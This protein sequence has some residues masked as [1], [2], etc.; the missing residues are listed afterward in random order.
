[1]RHSRFKNSTVRLIFL[2]LPDV[3][4]LLRITITLLYARFRNGSSEINWQVVPGAVS[5]QFASH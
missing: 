4:C 5:K 3:V 2:E 1:M